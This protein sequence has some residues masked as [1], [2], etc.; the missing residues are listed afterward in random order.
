MKKLA[1]AV[2]FQHFSPSDKRT[3]LPAKFWIQSADRFLALSLIAT[4]LCFELVGDLGPSRF[5]LWLLDTRLSLAPPPGAD[6]KRHAARE[7]VLSLLAPDDPLSQAGHRCG[8]LRA[9][10]GGRPRQAGVSWPRALPSAYPL[11]V[12]QCRRPP[13][14]A[15]GRPRSDHLPGDQDIS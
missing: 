13:H 9:R 15:T 11:C 1:R 14:V 8:P 12:W 3:P 4:K 6:S 2:I 7:A 10:R 5:L